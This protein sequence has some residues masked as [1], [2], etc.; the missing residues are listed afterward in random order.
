MPA[1]KTW[2]GLSLSN[3]LVDLQHNANIIPL[4]DNLAEAK[5]GTFAW[6]EHWSK[7]NGDDEIVW[8]PDPHL[9]E[10]GKSQA[11]AI[12]A[13]WANEVSAGI[14][15]PHKKYCSPL[16]RALDTCDFI[17]EGHP[18]DFL[19]V[20]NCR[21]ENGVHTCDKRSSRSDIQKYKPHFA[22]EAGLTEEDLLWHPTIRETK[23]EVAERARKVLD[24]IFKTDTGS[25]DVFISITA[26]GGFINGFLTTLGRTPYPLPTGGVIPLLVKAIPETV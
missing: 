26:H 17:F 24:F 11:R 1:L 9:T 21:E 12:H 15:Q 14:P 10:L 2:T 25:D 20:E 3:R 16:R 18:G 19:V 7:L 13:E 5:Y 6:D 8:G 4:S 22:I 23:P